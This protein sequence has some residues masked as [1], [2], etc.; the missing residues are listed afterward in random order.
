MSGSTAPDPES[1]TMTEFSAG[2][3]ASDM[4]LPRRRKKPCASLILVALSPLAASGIAPVGGA[5][6]LPVQARPVET[7]AMQIREPAKLKSDKPFRGCE[8]AGQ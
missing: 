7:L 8:R 5:R 1:P 2:L 6:T 3:E 4:C